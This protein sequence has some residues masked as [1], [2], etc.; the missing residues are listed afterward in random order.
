MNRVR[1]DHFEM[2]TGGVYVPRLADDRE[3]LLCM[4]PGAAEAMLA[5]AELETEICLA[6][7]RG[8]GKSL[9]LL[10]D[11][12]QEIGKWGPSMARHHLPQIND[13]GSRILDRV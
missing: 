10:A 13:L 2:S 11:Y 6:G 4:Q 8:P 12:L 5:A 1:V 7:P 3:V 9:A